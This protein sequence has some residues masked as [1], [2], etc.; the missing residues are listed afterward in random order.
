MVLPGSGERPFP[1]KFQLGQLLS[2]EAA[3]A[4]MMG[5]AMGRPKWTDRAPSDIQNWLESI[6][7]ERVL[8][9]EPLGLARTNV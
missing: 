7:Y 5:L 9:S 8:T 4:E 3:R 1:A 2:E 6:G